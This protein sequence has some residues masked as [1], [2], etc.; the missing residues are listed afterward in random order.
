MSKI[1]GKFY[2][3][4][5]KIF[6]ES[7]AVAFLAVFINILTSMVIKK[8]QTNIYEIGYNCNIWILLISSLFIFISSLYI[9]RKLIDYPAETDLKNHIEYNIKREESF[10][11][12]FVV[13]FLIFSIDILVVLI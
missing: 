11:L 8:S 1:I 3:C 13:S 6:F 4:L 12:I 7:S 5:G 9:H 10:F 2:T